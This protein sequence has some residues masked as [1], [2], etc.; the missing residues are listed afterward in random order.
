MNTHEPTVE[1]MREFSK[2]FDSSEWTQLIKNSFFIKYYDKDLIL[3]DKIAK[4]LLSG[5]TVL[6]LNDISQ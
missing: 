1:E 5:R 3:V 4:R 6:S 2:K